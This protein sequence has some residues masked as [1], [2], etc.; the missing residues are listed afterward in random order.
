LGNDRDMFLCLGKNGTERDQTG[1]LTRLWFVVPENYKT[2][3]TPTILIGTSLITTDPKTITLGEGTYC[4]H[5]PVLFPQVKT[6]TGVPIPKSKIVK[7]ALEGKIAAVFK[8]NVLGTPE[9]VDEEQGDIY[10]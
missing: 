4:I 9:K 5:L 1:Q 8:A 10:E 3:I 7:A 6:T 2:K